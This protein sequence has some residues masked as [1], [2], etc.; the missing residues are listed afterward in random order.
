MASSGRLQGKIA[1]VTGAAQGIGAAYA[2]RLASEGAVVAVCD[3]QDAS[4]VVDAIHG[5]GGS[6]TAASIDVTDAAAVAAFVQDTAAQFGPIDILV[7]NASLF[8][9]LQRKKFSDITAAEWD[10]VLVVN[11][12]SVLEC[13]KAVVPAMRERQHGKIIN[14]A[15][16]TVHFGQPMFLH[17]VASKGAVIA[18]THALARE[19]G[20]F[21]IAVNCIAPGLTMSET[22][23]RDTPVQVTS[24]AAN[25]RCFKR[26]QTPEDLC[27]SLL[28]LASD[29]SDFVTGQTFIVDGGHILS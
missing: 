17:Y 1:M 9:G 15:S 18:M 25:V 11:T 27:G 23:K 21:G 24:M 14:I 2:R 26:E 12:R 29:D 8:G 3:L 28:Y 20:D 16:T 6:A 5:E 7:N 4:D 19:L 10:R 13:T 22:V